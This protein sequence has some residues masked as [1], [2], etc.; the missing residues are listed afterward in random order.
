M[1]FYLLHYFIRGY[2]NIYSSPLKNIYLRFNFFTMAI[3]IFSLWIISDICLL[4]LV[5][6]WLLSAA[7]GGGGGTRP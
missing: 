4:C 2:R 5:H 7:V 1:N 6:G 3:Q